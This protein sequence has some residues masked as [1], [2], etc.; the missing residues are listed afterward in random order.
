MGQQVGWAADSLDL[1]VVLVCLFFATHVLQSHGSTFTLAIQS[2]HDTDEPCAGPDNPPC[3]VSVGGADNSN[4]GGGRPRR[5]D[6]SV[7]FCVHWYLW[8][9]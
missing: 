6:Q 9:V 3:F 5:R 4:D 2:G 7:S 1:W 8:V